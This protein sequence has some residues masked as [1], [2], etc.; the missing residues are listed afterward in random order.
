MRIQK[1]LP[2]IIT[3][4]IYHFLSFDLGVHIKSQSSPPLNAV[5]F[6]ALSSLPSDLI[7]YQL[8]TR[9]QLSIVDKDLDQSTNC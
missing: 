4:D 8:S 5:E 3:N 7:N 1:V 9:Y 6:P 2:K